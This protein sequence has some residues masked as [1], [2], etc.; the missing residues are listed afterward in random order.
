[1]TLALAG[2][3]EEYTD[4]SFDSSRV[5]KFADGRPS[6]E[7]QRMTTQEASQRP[8]QKLVFRAFITLKNGKRLYAAAIGKKAFPIWVP[9]K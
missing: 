9:D 1:L 5:F 3:S 2:E 7:I 6:Q 8:G 4:D